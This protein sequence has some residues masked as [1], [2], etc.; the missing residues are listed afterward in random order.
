MIWLFVLAYT[1]EE[2]AARLEML[3][4]SV[5]RTSPAELMQAYRHTSN[6]ERGACGAA[7]QRLRVECLVTSAKRY[8]ANQAAECAAYQDVIVSLVLSEQALVSETRRFE[9]MQNVRGWRRDVA[10]EVQRQQATLA[11]HMR[12]AARGR[13]DTT[14]ALARAID[15]YCASSAFETGLSWQICAASLVWFTSARN[16]DLSEVTP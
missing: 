14:P 3:I 8:C 1:A 11:A 10:R 15:G 6:A 4:D 7:N 5:K 12:L 16:I 13:L 2:R 9:L